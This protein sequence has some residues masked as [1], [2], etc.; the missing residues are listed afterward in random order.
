[1]SFASKVWGVINQAKDAGA[2]IAI[3]HLLAKQLE[4]YG[5]LKELRLNS[6]ERKVHLEVLLKGE[7]HSLGVDVLDYELQSAAD[8]DYI[9]LKRVV[10]SREWVTELLR[11]FVVGRRHPIPHQHSRMVRLVLNG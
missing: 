5:E 2:S 4:P 7:L 10:D 8:Q 3:E 9:V 1:M 11:N 6:R